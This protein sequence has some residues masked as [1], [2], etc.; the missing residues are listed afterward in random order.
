MGPVGPSPENDRS[1]A[2]GSLSVSPD[3]AD[4][5][6]IDLGQGVAAGGCFYLLALALM[7][8]TTPPSMLI[9]MGGALLFCAYSA[10]RMQW[11]EAAMAFGLIVGV[12]AN[13]F[14]PILLFLLFMA[15]WGRT[16]RAVV[17]PWIALGL[18]AFAFAAG[19]VEPSMLRDLKQPNIETLYYYY[20]IPV[21]FG[22][23]SCATLAQFTVAMARSHT[24]EVSVRLLGAQWLSVCA[25]LLAMLS[26]GQALVRYASAG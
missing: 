8:T 10:W 19:I 22:A 15:G 5:F 2:P 26:I 6:L 3:T 7:G 21:I 17:L 25:V 9:V 20:L 1:L 18:A 14:A 12:S 24:L 11:R 4:L 16:D 13:L 23:L